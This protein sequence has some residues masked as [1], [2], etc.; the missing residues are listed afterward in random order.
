MLNGQ[1]KHPN[2]RLSGGM[3]AR[4]G[5][6]PGSRTASG[7]EITKKGC[8]CMKAAFTFCLYS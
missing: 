7:A 3:G 6:R 8:L 1:L 2:I 5:A 4:K